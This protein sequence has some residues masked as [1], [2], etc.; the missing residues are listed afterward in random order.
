MN[1]GLRWQVR[2][3]MPALPGGGAKFALMDVP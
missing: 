2:H 3:C 1:P